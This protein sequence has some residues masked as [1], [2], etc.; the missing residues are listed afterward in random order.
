MFPLKSLVWHLAKCVI[1]FVI[2][3]DV[4]CVNLFQYLTH[5]ILL[6]YTWVKG[7]DCLWVANETAPCNIS[8]I[9]GLIRPNKGKLYNLSPCSFQ[10]MSLSKKM[11]VKEGAT[12]SIPWSYPDFIVFGIAPKCFWLRDFYILL[13]F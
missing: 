6:S 13:V 11:T 2:L 12:A 9:N 8:T 1:P 3:I 10:N 4:A 5:S 7:G